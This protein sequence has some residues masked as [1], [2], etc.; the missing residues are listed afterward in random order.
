MKRAIHEA[1]NQVPSVGA[2]KRSLEETNGVSLTK[3]SS[4]SSAVVSSSEHSRSSYC[5]SSD[6]DLRPPVF[7]KS[8]QL[9]TLPLKKQ[10][11]RELHVSSDSDS[12]SQ[13]SG[14]SKGLEILVQAANERK[15]GGAVKKMRRFQENA[16]NQKDI[17][18]SNKKKEDNPKSMKQVRDRHIPRGPV[19]RATFPEKLMEVLNSSE[20]KNAISWLPNGNSFVILSPNLLTNNILPK[21]FKEAKFESFTRKLNRWGFK[22]ISADNFP[23]DLAYFHHLFQRDFPQ[24]CHGMSGGKK[25]E[26]SFSHLRNPNFIHSLHVGAPSYGTEHR[27]NPQSLM[28]NSGVFSTNSAPALRGSS[29]AYHTVSMQMA[30][31]PQENFQEIMEKIVLKQRLGLAT[32]A[33]AE[34]EHQLEALMRESE[35]VRAIKAELALEETFM[36]QQ[37]AVEAYKKSLITSDPAVELLRRHGERHNKFRRLSE[38]TLSSSTTGGVFYGGM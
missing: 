35:E 27:Y 34:R 22:R 18:K 30:R 36:R 4:Y 7:K 16:K 17:Q 11:A 24:L 6:D 8:R 21:H 9:K 5:D 13:A 19:R 14:E 15:Q 10:R 3:C 26:E 12:N 25:P 29:N 38:M 1:S 32:K 33:L 37:S 23:N 2:V 31:P 20:A 28:A